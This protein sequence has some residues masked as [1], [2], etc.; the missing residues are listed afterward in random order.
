MKDTIQDRPKRTKRK[1]SQ[2]ESPDVHKSQD[3]NESNSLFDQHFDVNVKNIKN[4]TPDNKCVKLDQSTENNSI[5]HKIDAISND[6]T[7]VKMIDKNPISDI[8]KNE[9]TRDVVK[10][11]I[12]QS[13]LVLKTEAKSI[14]KDRNLFDDLCTYETI[15]MA[16]IHQLP[17][18]I[19]DNCILTNDLMQYKS[20]EQVDMI[21]IHV[22][23]ST[24]EITKSYTD[25]STLTVRLNPI[26]LRRQLKYHD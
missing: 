25:E 14:D 23:V 3:T 5:V 16:Y 6:T 12:E 2:D 8:I 21:F 24:L 4:D 7:N 13:K 18:F 20:G 22:A 9:S 17:I 15:K 26:T 10:Q 11:M 1:Y 19:L